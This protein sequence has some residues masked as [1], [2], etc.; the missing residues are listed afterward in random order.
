MALRPSGSPTQLGCLSGHGLHVVSP[1]LHRFWLYSPTKTAVLNSGKSI[2]LTF[3]YDNLKM[4]LCI[5]KS[6]KGCFINE[7]IQPE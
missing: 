6:L 4:L 7:N 1:C 5:L 3:L 2:Y